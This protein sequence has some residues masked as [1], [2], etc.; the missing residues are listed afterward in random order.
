[1]S[2]QFSDISTSSFQCKFRVKAYAA[3]NK[4]TAAKEYGIIENSLKYL[5]KRKLTLQFE[6]KL[7]TVW[8]DK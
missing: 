1:M 5:E 7:E 6:N 3:W 8:K 2:V 4:D